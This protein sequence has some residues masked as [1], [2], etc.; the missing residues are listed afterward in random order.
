MNI[1][2]VNTLNLM[3][4]GNIV[5]FKRAFQPAHKVAI[6]ADLHV[7]A[8]N[9]LSLPIYH[10]LNGTKVEATEISK[11]IY[12][13]WEKYTEILDAWKVDEICGIGDFIS[14]TAKLRNCSLDTM[15]LDDQK[16]MAIKLLEQITQGRELHISSGTPFH[17]SIDTKAHNDIAKRLNGEYHDGGYF[18]RDYD[19]KQVLYAHN[20][21]SQS[22]YP[23]GVMER[24]AIFTQFGIA[25][26]KIRNTCLTIGA[27]HHKYDE[28]YRN[29]TNVVIPGWQGY[30]AIKATVKFSG[31][32]QPD[33]GGI[34]LL[35]NDKGFVVIPYVFDVQTM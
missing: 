26:N 15:Q 19:G 25:S 5:N 14:S 4:K 27:H 13:C 30:Y 12:N 16:D 18:F 9:A 20:T 7:G 17:D 35:V 32:R 29:Y 1:Q 33:I 24:E 11:V 2:E 34:V 6:I 31:I 3:N 10:C 28:I 8:N 21:R 22:L 23:L